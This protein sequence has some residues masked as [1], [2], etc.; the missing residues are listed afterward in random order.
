M[1]P[2]DRRLLCCQIRVSSGWTVTDWAGTGHV[3]PLIDDDDDG[4]DDGD[5]LYVTPDMTLSLNN[6][7]YWS[8]PHQ[9]TGNKVI[10]C[11]ASPSAKYCN[12]CGR[13]YFLSLGVYIFH[14]FLTSG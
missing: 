9:Y 10:A 6:D 13:F 14:Y 5:V 3:Q 1:A 11:C 8:A 4:D 7:I 2:R 12:V